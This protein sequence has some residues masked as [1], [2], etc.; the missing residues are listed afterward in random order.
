MC[1]REDS[2]LPGRHLTRDLPNKKKECWLFQLI[3][4]GV[5]KSQKTNLPNIRLN[6]DPLGGSRVVTRGQTD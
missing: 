6:E 1:L 4:E 3:L 5:D 2:Q